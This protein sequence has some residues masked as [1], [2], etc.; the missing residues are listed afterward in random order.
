MVEQVQAA[1]HI[2]F[3]RRRNPLG[4]GFG[5]NLQLDVQILQNRHG[6][7]LRVGEIRLIHRTD[8]PVDD[9]LFN[10]LQAL[11]A[12]DDQLAHRQHKVGFQ[13]HG[14]FLIRVIHVDIQRIDVVAADGRNADDLPVQPPD[15]RRILRF[16]VA[17]D[18]VVVRHQKHVDHFPL[19]RKRLAAARR[20]Q[21]QSVRVA[22]QLAIHQNHVV[23]QRIHAVIQRAF[24][25]LKQFLRRKRNENAQRAGRQPAL[26]AN[27]VH[28]QR[29]RRLHRPLL[30]KIQRHQRTVH[31][32]RDAPALLHIRLELALRVRRVDQNK[33]QHQH[34]LIVVLQAFKHVLCARIQRRQVA[35]QDIHVIAGTHGALLLLDL[36]PVQLGDL[37]LDHLHGFRLVDGADVHGHDQA[38]VH[39]QKRFQRPVGQVGGGNLQERRAAKFL[40]DSE[41]APVRELERGG[42]DK[43]PRR[44]PGWR[45]PVPVKRER[46]FRVH[47]EDAVQQRQPRFAVQRLRV[48]AH[49]LEIAQQ[50]R[51]DAFQPRLRV[52]HTVRLDGERQVFRLAQAVVAPREL[53]LEHLRIF[54]ADAVKIVL[55]R[56]HL[57][58]VIS[59]AL[60]V[61][62][63]EKRKLEGNRAV[64]VV[65][66]L[67][68]APKDRVLV[69]VFGEL[70]IDVLKLNRLVVAVHVHPADAVRVHPLIGDRL[71]RADAVSV[72]APRAADDRLN[73]PLFASCELSVCCLEQW[74][75]PRFQAAPAFPAAHRCS[76][77]DRFCVLGADSGS[78]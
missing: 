12:A 29:Q 64:K 18:D 7:R 11:L 44:Q 75:S 19:R 43:V 71:L 37:A 42:R 53:V 14:V 3:K 24:A 49:P 35:G 73:L 25:F 77:S 39:R 30:L 10:R 36:R 41:R 76:G 6:F 22:Q 33:R 74:L 34:A 72:P 52:A 26:D 21:N 67:A 70:I 31:R 40:P 27:R 4:F 16:R 63:I 47:V 20:T 17:D 38:A 61:F 48:N 58:A 15:Q 28:A 68:P 13:R 57:N 45:E 60:S 59:S 50:F 23:G 1:M 9:R 2:D 51:F 78:R 5:L 69:L 32:L 65:D 8:A 66:E 62:Q 46:L 56:G 55:P 54:L